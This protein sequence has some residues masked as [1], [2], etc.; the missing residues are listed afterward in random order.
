MSRE[1][2]FLMFL[3]VRE[4]MFCQNVI[5]MV[6]MIF[7]LVGMSLITSAKIPAVRLPEVINFYILV[8]VATYRLNTPRRLR[9]MRSAFLDQSIRWGW[10]DIGLEVLNTALYACLGLNIMFG[11]PT[12][13]VVILDCLIILC[14]MSQ[15][16]TIPL[17]AIE[18]D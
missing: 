3:R 16:L 11:E 9:Y 8:V 1:R 10:L 4:Y 18:E 7:W 12:P 5:L 2:L 14:V 6:A 17:S 13:F 15:D